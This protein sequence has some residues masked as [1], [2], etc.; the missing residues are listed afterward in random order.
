MSMGIFSYKSNNTSVKLDN[1]IVGLYIATVGLDNGIVELYN[2][3]VKFDN[4]TVGL[5]NG[6]VKLDIASVGL[7]NADVELDGGIVGL[8]LP[9]ISKKKGQ[10]V[11]L[12]FLIILEYHSPKQITF[13]MKQ[14][15]RSS[16]KQGEHSS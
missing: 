16:H 9:L 11:V 12:S 7:H 14:P 8:N 3:S 15:I 2:A 4:A 10:R 5:Y 6:N 1:G 13:S